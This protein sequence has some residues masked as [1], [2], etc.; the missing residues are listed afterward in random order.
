MSSLPDRAE[1][2][3]VPPPR[4][5]HRA[6]GMHPGWQ[7][8]LCAWVSGMFTIS[9]MACVIRWAVLDEGFG[10]GAIIIGSIAII[11]FMIGGSRAERLTD[12][13]P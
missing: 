13:L 4:R 8:F 12:R 3:R 5:R 2:P 7:V 6:R 11:L 10:W 1:S 9:A